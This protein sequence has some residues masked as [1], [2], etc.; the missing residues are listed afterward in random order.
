MGRHNVV[1]ADKRQSES[2]PMMI[3]N[4]SMTGSSASCKLS[5]MTP[6]FGD[7]VGGKFSESLGAEVRSV[8]IR[9]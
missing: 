5:V 3:K 8:R 7:E 6:D 4:D 2:W 1:I 9:G